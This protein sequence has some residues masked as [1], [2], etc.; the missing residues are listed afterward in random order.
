MKE[1]EFLEKIIDI[2][3]EELNH[4]PKS[5]KY[6]EIKKDDIHWNFIME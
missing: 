1:S 4:N 2:G 3:F 5:V 6:Y